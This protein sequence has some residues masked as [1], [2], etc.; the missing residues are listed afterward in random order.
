MHFIFSD[1]VRQLGVTGFCFVNN[2]IA[3][4]PGARR[5]VDAYIDMEISREQARLAKHEIE[6]NRILLGFRRL[7]D[8][9]GVNNKKLVSSPENLL[10]FVKNTGKF[11]RVNPV[12]DIYNL[13]SIKYSLAIGAHDTSCIQ[14]NVTLRLAKGDERYWPLGG[15]TLERV[16]A[17]EYVYVDDAND[18][19][20]R[21]EVRQVEKTKVTDDTKS[22][23]YIVQGNEETQLSYIK[24]SVD[25][26]ISTTQRFCGGNVQIL[27]NGE[28]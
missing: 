13:I 15:K 1:D 8:K 14:G 18:V 3:F 25:E 10:R 17:G 7:H 23:F 20:C 26:L 5:A 2:H 6:D 28:G 24:K 21:L 4:S 19:I 22:C 11:P 16:K 27:F 9:V 12:V